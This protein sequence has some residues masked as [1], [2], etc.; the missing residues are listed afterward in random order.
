MRSGECSSAASRLTTS[1]GQSIDA[2]E[3]PLRVTDQA[4]WCFAVRGYPRRAGT[5]RLWL[6]LP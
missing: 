4:R 2:S 3:G 5:L 1:N 6:T